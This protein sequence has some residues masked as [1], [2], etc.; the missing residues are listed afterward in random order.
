MTIITCLWFQNDLEGRARPLHQPVPRLRG[1][2]P[3]RSMGG[4]DDEV[5]LADWRMNGTEFRA[6]CQTSEFR[7]N[8]SMSLSVTCADQAEVDRYWDGLHRRRR[9]GVA[10]RLAEGPVGPV[11]ADRAAAQLERADPRRPGAA[12]DRMLPSVGS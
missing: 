9:R 1:A 5:W 8:E 11:V 7:F 2:L 3:A 4:M 6:I 10:V 12:R